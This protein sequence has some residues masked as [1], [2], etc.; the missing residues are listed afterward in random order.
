[1]AWW[2]TVEGID[3][4]A[5]CLCILLVVMDTGFSH[6][7]IVVYLRGFFFFFTPGQPM[8]NNKYYCLQSLGWM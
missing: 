8:L 5:W 4:S 2:R 6:S 1:M 3:C 7:S